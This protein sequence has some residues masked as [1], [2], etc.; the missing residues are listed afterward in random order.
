MLVKES[1]C[2][3]YILFFIGLVHYHWLLL[4]LCSCSSVA[5]FWIFFMLVLCFHFYNKKNQTQRA[6]EW[7]MCTFFDLKVRFGISVLFLL[8]FIMFYF[9]NFIFL[10]FDLMNLL[11][12]NS[13]SDQSLG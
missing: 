5:L 10:M 8:C 12:F 3:V 13:I 1:S 2:L 11:T 4:L 6:K 7:A 9:V